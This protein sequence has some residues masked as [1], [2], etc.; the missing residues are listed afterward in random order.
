MGIGGNFGGSAAATAGSKPTLLLFDTFAG[1]ATP[2][3]RHV[4][5]CLGA[6]FMGLQTLDTYQTG[7]L[8]S[9][10]HENITCNFRLFESGNIHLLN[11]DGS[12]GL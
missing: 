1:R 12:G 7:S 8:G 3:K 9:L 10:F 6:S 11:D 5:N 2:L 4:E